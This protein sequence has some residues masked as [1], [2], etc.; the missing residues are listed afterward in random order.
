MIDHM[1][2]FYD[3]N[4]ISTYYSIRNRFEYFL[5]QSM[6]EW[7]DKIDWNRLIIMQSLSDEFSS[8]WFKD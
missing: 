4:L 8:N 1:L 5:I 2:Q 6:I 3:T 7:I